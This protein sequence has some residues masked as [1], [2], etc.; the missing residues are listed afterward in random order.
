MKYPSSRFFSLVSLRKEGIY[1]YAVFVFIFWFLIT[2]N[3]ICQ[4]NNGWIPNR[5]SLFYSVAN[6]HENPN[7][8]L[9]EKSRTLSVAITVWQETA[10]QQ[11]IATI[12]MKDW[13]SSVEW[14][15]DIVV[16]SYKG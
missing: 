7:V 10:V 13:K 12:Q 15:G 16:E 4:K 5:V 8:P 2:F 11:D 3:Q 1:D 6:F 14:A 9:E